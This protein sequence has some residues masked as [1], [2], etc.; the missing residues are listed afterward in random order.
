MGGSLHRGAVVRRSTA[1]LEGRTW[2]WLLSGGL[3]LVVCLGVWNL[4]RRPSPP[5]PSQVEV[6]VVRPVEAVAALGQLEPAGE[7]RRLAAPASGFGGTP[8][9]AALNVD[10][11]DA[12]Q[13]GQVLAVFDNRPQLLADL[14]GVKARLQT[15]DVQIRM[16]QREV[17][18]YKQAATEGAATLVL[19][20]EKQ[21]ELVKLEGQRMEAVAESRGLNADLAN[22]EL[23]SPVDGVVL[24]IHSRVG[25]RPGNE[26]VLE[27][28]DNQRMEALIE[29]YESD[30][31]RVSVGQ[32]VKLTSEN[33]GFKGILDGR[34]E[35]I[36][37][38]VRQRK[39]LSTDPTG[40]ADARVVEVRV[41]LA[42]ESIARVSRLTGMKVIARFQPS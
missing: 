1:S 33:G 32:A 38:Q 8:R 34:V 36:S 26:G 20:E 40:D 31:E 14:A 3:G 22:S 37:P 19:L 15:L 9:I 7:V 28:G 13:R 27:V 12:V 23:K 24:R 2:L 42:P 5:P 21:D 29:V 6:P 25:E 39:V 41:H 16:Q 18:R 4:T 17:R 11:G 35:S 10:E 30:V